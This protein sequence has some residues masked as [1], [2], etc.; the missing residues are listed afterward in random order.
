MPFKKIFDA[1]HDRLRRSIEHH[2]NAARAQECYDKVKREDSLRGI[3]GTTL[4]DPSKLS[5]QQLTD[6][7]YLTHSNLQTARAWRIKESMRY[8]YANTMNSAQAEALF[9]H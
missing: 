8:L 9:M 7:H 2:V 6:F 4:T 5:K 1:A 3:R